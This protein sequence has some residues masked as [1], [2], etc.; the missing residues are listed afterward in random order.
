MDRKVNYGDC[1]VCGNHATARC[2]H[3]KL[4]PYCGRACQKSHY[5]G[6]K[7]ICLQLVHTMGYVA[8]LEKKVRRKYHPN[9]PFKNSVG[10]FHELPGVADY[11]YERNYF[12]KLCGDMGTIPSLRLAVSETQEILRLNE[13]DNFAVRERL[14]YHYLRLPEYQ[15]IQDCYDFVKWWLLKMHSERPPEEGL[16]GSDLCEP[17]FAAALHKY[18]PMQLTAPTEA[19]PLGG[20]EAVQRCPGLSSTGQAARLAEAAHT[21]QHRGLQSGPIEAVQIAV[22]GHRTRA[23]EAAR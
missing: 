8:E 7:E 12:A 4:A 17:L 20:T 11:L 15:S 6:H 21:E 1:I 23:A 16:S 22:T 19:R 5:K 14:P 2:G 13:E 9:N 10:R 18:A 3:C